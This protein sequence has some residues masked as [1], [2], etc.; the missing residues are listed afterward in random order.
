MIPEAEVEREDVVTEESD[1]TPRRDEHPG[2]G[3]ARG[4]ARMEAFA[5][6]VFAIAFTLPVTEIELP[7]PG[8]DYAAQLTALWPSYLGYVLSALVIGLYWVQHHFAGAIYRVTGHPLLLAT[9]LFLL[10]IGF[11]AFPTRTFAENILDPKTREIGAIFYTF[12]LA[13]TALAWWLKWRIG[14]SCGQV[15]ARLDPAYVA[16]LDRRY[17]ISAALVAAAA[18]LSLVRWEAGLGLAAVVTLAYLKP[19]ETPVYRTEAPEVED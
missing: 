1:D 5:D 11:V 14:R 4:T 2:Q 9:V 6:A 16:R 7:E 18:T 13:A 8:V 15:D 19:P 3:V 12:A 10:A 17:T